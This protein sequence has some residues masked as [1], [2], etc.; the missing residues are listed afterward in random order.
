[1]K[2]KKQDKTNYKE[3]GRNKNIQNNNDKYEK[4]KKIKKN[5]KNI[6]RN[7]HL[8]TSWEKM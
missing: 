4:N 5:F 8:S 2:L 3:R 7:R 6:N 1:M